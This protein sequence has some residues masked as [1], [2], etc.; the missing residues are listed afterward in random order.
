MLLTVKHTKQPFLQV[1]SISELCSVVENE[2]ATIEWKESSYWFFEPTSFEMFLTEK[3]ELGS[4]LAFSRK[5]HS[6]SL[7]LKKHHSINYNSICCLDFRR[8]IFPV[9][10][11]MTTYDR[12][13]VDGSSMA[14]KS[15]RA[16]KFGLQMANSRC[17]WSWSFPQWAEQWRNCSLA[18]RGGLCWHKKGLK[19]LRLA[20]LP[21]AP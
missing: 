14:P 20:F 18:Q 15:G 12:K 17:V 2:R 16:K 1:T 13:I 19:W 10:E 3:H 9:H 6:K 4:T 7:S 21:P 8:F 5:P 11:T